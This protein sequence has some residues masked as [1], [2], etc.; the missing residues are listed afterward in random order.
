MSSPPS[1]LSDGTLC[2]FRRKALFPCPVEKAIELCN[3]VARERMPPAGFVLT[4]SAVGIESVQPRYE[5]CG[6]RMNGV[7]VFQQH[8]APALWDGQHAQP[9]AAAVRLEGRHRH[10]G[11]FVPCHFAGDAES[12]DAKKHSCQFAHRVARRVRGRERHHVRKAL[13]PQPKPPVLWWLKA[14]GE[15]MRLHPGIIVAASRDGAYQYAASGTSP[16][17][18]DVAERREMDPFVDKRY[19][20]DGCI[21]GLVDGQRSNAR[22]QKRIFRLSSNDTR[23]ST[24][25]ESWIRSE[26]IP[27]PLYRGGGRVQPAWARRD[28]A[29]WDGDLS[30]GSAADEPSDH[31]RV[32][33]NV[34]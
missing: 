6:N 13:E 2:P 25:R 18:R 31:R 7:V 9:D 19:F 23:T 32:S 5:G 34:L 8:C 22:P 14:A 4:F 10:C 17:P 3:R 27:P 21:G 20:A 11:L 12:E 1:L 33:D 26:E 16:Q 30:V 28:L 24:A 15:A 29:R